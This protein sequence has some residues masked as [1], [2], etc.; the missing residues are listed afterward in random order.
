MHSRRLAQAKRGDAFEF[1]LS[2][3]EG[4]GPRGCPG[5]EGRPLARRWKHVG[6]H[7]GDASMPRQFDLN[8]VLRRDR[9]QPRQ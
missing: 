7:A 1:L 6:C 3:L 5:G 2:P 9:G 4:E 8:A